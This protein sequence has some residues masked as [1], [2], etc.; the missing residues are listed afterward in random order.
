MMFSTAQQVQMASVYNV[1]TFDGTT[2]KP[3]IFN[4]FVN[5]YVVSHICIQCLPLIFTQM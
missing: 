4:W 3:F 1:A 5:I 2:G